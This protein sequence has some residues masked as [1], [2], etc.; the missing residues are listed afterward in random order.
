[1]SNQGMLQVNEIH[2][3]IAGVIGVELFQVNKG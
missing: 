3:N 1:M 2:K